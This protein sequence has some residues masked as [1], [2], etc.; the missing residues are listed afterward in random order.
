MTCWLQSTLQDSGIEWP[1]LRS[2]IPRMA[3][4]RQ[5]ALG[6]FM[7]SLGV[8][9]RIK[10]CEPHERDQQFG[11]NESIDIG[12]SAG[13]PKEG[14]ARINKVS[15]MKPGLSKIIEKVRISRYFENPETDSHIA[16][17]ACCIDYADTWLSKRVPWLWQSPSANRSTTCDGCEVEVEL[18]TGVTWASRPIKRIQLRV[19]QES[20]IQLLLASHQNAGWI[21]HC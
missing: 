10:W 5:L 3:H 4:V 17:N 21:D 1:A 8:K 15:A 2:H 20:E 18:D 12:K 19:A 9:G 7:C 16:V 14:N 6:A 13:L 11:V